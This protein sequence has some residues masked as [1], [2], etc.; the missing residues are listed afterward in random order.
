MW[1]GVFWRVV[2][3]AAALGPF[4]TAFAQQKLGPINRV[5][6]NTATRTELMQIPK[7]GEKLAERIVEFRKANGPFKR[8]E[9]LM[10]VKGMGEKTFLGM[11]HQLT[12]GTQPPRWQGGPKK[13]LVP[14]P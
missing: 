5:N 6:I 12:V 10:N 3:L 14:T 11:R 1:V 13:G 2:V 4:A 8:V 9:E 7:I